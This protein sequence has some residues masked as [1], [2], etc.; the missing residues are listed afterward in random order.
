MS[1]THFHSVNSCQCVVSHYLR[2]HAHRWGLLIDYWNWSPEVSHFKLFILFIL[3]RHM[4]AHFHIVY[5]FILAI[6]SLYGWGRTEIKSFFCLTTTTTTTAAHDHIGLW[7]VTT[8]YHLLIL[9]SFNSNFLCLNE[10]KFFS[11]PFIERESCP[12]ERGEGER[13]SRVGAQIWIY[14]IDRIVLIQIIQTNCHTHSNVVC[15]YMSLSFFLSFF[16]WVYFWCYITWKWLTHTH[17]ECWSIN[18]NTRHLTLDLKW[19]LN[20]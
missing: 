3:F 14:W 11:F 7:L 6:I 2:T 5:L 12:I 1:E 4:H 19:K 16:F 18:T 9:L 10:M 20:I 17:I 8:F 13:S 15:C